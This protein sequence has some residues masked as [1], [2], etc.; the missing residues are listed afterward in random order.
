MAGT[1]NI[2]AYEEHLVRLLRRYPHG[3]TVADLC[4]ASGLKIQSVST[5]MTVM[6]KKGLAIWRGRKVSEST[7][8]SGK[9][10]FVND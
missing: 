8:A 1:T 3:I 7:G 10:W 5:A 2:S 4:A 9:L 6:G